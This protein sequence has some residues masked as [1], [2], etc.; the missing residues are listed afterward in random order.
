[1]RVIVTILTVL[2]LVIGLSATAAAADKEVTLTGKIMCAKCELGLKG[3]S[4]CQTV[5]KVKEGDKDVLYFFKD[6]GAREEYH[7]MVCGGGQKDGTV[8]G[9][10][11]EKDGKKWI[12]PKKVVYA[13]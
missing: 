9:V 11:T 5:M 8:T 7:E 3:V 13:K 10:V 12:A 1:M 6:K 4:K 2:A